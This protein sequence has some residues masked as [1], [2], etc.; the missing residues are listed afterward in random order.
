MQIPFEGGIVGSKSKLSA[1]AGVLGL[2]AIQA[3]PAHASTWTAVKL[4]DPSI[5]V[6]LYGVSCPS[7]SLCVAVGGNS[8][9]AVSKNPTGGAPEWSVFRPGGS[10]DLP[11]LPG[12]S[13]A[14]GGGQI[15]GV[16]CPTMG[17]C[18]AAS[19]DGDIYSSAN[20]AGGL[21]A[22]KVVGLREEREPRIHM[23]GIS[24][25]SPSLC[26]AV[27]YG[28]KIV[29]STD[30]AGDKTAWTLTELTQPFDLRGIS[31]ASASLC[32]A[33]GNEGS[34]L[35]STDPTGGPSAW[36]SMGAPAGESSMNGIS[37]RTPSLCVTGSASGIV[38]STDPAGGPS[39]WR[40][41]G[42]GTGLPIKGFSCPSTLACAAVDNNADVIASTDPTGGDGAWWFKNVLPYPWDGPPA[43][44]GKAQGNGT[45]GLSCPVL[46]L[47]VAVGQDSQVLTSTDPFVR[48]VPESMNRRKS[49]RPRVLI[50]GHPP[51]RLNR[52]KGGARA[53]FRFRAIGGKASGFKCKLDRRPYRSCRSPKRYRAG[54]GKHVFK[55][56]AIAPGGAKGPA[57]AF[58][59]RV[60]RVTERP[61]VG[62]CP[63]DRA[64]RGLKLLLAPCVNAD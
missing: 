44:D 39:S 37:C 48:D 45:F 43:G 47:C 29:F 31:C 40:L 5:Q 6:A 35:V 1:V 53:T 42:A 25:P 59:F 10:V 55:V 51:K 16:S 54:R 58:H 21:S 14:Y 46:S 34:V 27:A 22:W 19:F 26:V 23:G 60:G 17:L 8:T 64:A 24:C 2:L 9:V 32:A 4:P 20:P 33:V 41:A 12:G 63:S 3:G 57:A 56:R 38:L 15:R 28:G 49:K 18:V 7:S 11:D 30:P 62:S 36:R 52:G 13:V 50:T 61:P